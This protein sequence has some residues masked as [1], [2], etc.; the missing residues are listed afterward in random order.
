MHEDELAGSGGDALA[1]SSV[2]AEDPAAFDTKMHPPTYSE[3]A[4]MPDEPVDYAYPPQIQGGNSAGSVWPSLVRLQ[5]W[6]ML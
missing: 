5:L 2:L 3:V 6:C 4:A 1:D